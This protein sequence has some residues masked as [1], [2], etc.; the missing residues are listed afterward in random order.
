M[1]RAGARFPDDQAEV[2]FSDPFVEQLADLDVDVAKDV[3]AKIVR[4]CENP[5]GKHPLSAG[6]AGLNT[7]EVDHKRMR[8]I[9]RATIA[10]K[11][12]ETSLIEVLCVGMRRDN[13]A[14][15]KGQQLFDAGVIDEDELNQ[16]WDAL[17]LLDV[18]A[19]RIGLDDWD[20]APEPAEPHMVELVVQL[21]IADRSLAQVLS[22]REIDQLLR[23]WHESDPIQATLGQIGLDTAITPTELIEKRDSARCG[24]LMPRAKAHCIRIRG[25][26]GPCRRS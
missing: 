3:L 19:H 11:P 16:I 9:Y 7:I 1:V 26:N 8:C 5:S 13:E 25:H 17:G 18:A 24:K 6:L 20:H 4:L 15:E 14:Y 2:V 23:S 10:A 12:G 21:G 22:H